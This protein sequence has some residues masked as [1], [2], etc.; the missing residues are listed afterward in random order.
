M[1]DLTTAVTT[2]RREI[3]VTNIISS[4]EQTE[5]SGERRP[6]PAAKLQRDRQQR[7]L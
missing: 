3:G 5:L 6:C 4:D 2:G 1:A 7:L